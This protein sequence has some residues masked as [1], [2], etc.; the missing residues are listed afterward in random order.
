MDPV[1][2]RD[3]IHEMMRIDFDRGGLI[4]P[5]FNNNLDAFHSRVKGFDPDTTGI[6]LSWFRF[7][8]VWSD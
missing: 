5:S 4:I 3:Y 7:D 6:P 2:Q 8:R 1:K